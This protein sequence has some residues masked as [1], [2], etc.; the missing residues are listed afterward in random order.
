MM[1]AG[2]GEDAKDA[3]IPLMIWYGV[4]PMVKPTRGRVLTLAS[5][6]KIPLLRQY[7]A[8]RM[9]EPD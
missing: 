3:M 1:R 7:I 8:R 9:A 2:R 6:S 5:H 4:E